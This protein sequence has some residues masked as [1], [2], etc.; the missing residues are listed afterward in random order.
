MT[1][2]FFQ[3]GFGGRLPGIQVAS[4]NEAY[5]GGFQE[6]P[7]YMPNGPY[8][9][10]PT[11]TFRDNVSKTFGKHNL[12]FG[13]YLV[14][15]QK[16]ELDG[17]NPSIGGFLTFDNT[18]A[19]TTGNA[20]A[21]L[22]M[23]KISSFQQQSQQVKYYNRY[24]IVEPYFQDD[25]RVTHKLTLNLGLRVSMFGTYRERYKQA[26]NFEAAKYLPGASSIDPA[27]GEVI[28]DQFNGMVQCGGPGIPPGCMKGHLFN[29]APRIGFAYDP[30]GDGKTAI[31]GGYG[32]FYEHTNGNEGNT[33]SLFGSPP[34][35]LN[36]TQSN[37]ASYDGVSGAL[38]LPLNVRSIP[39]SA[40]WPYMQQWHFDI[41]RD[42][43]AH[44]VATASYVGSKGTH[45]TLQRNLN[46]LHPTPLGDNPYKPGEAISGADCGTSFDEFGVPLN[47]TTPSG[48]PI[49]G[50]AAVNLAVAACG[51]NADV[52]RTEFPGFSGITRLEPEANSSYH[53]FQLAARRTIGALN[54]S[55]AYTYSHSIDNSSSRSDGTFVDSFDLARTRAN[56]NFDQRHILTISYVYDL[57][58]FKGGGIKNRVLGGWQFSGITSIQSGTPFTVQN[59][60]DFSDS[61][62]V[63]N[64]LVN[65][66]SFADIIGNPRSGFD[67]H[68]PGD[69][70]PRLYNPDAYAT[71]QGLTFGNSGRNSLTLPR[72]TNFDFS[73]FKRFPLGEAR[74]FEF[75]WDNF[76]VFNHT[77]FSAIDQDF[78]SSTFLE[79]T[80]AHS[81]RIMQFGAKII[82]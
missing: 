5:G 42:L 46:Q 41:Q 6:D 18:S 23:G 22:L 35:V 30:F 68:V 59:G 47:A 54:L 14:F 80:S 48:V 36:P 50:Q 65:A 81:A 17:S 38:P 79:A 82:F 40:V 75:R 33:E 25:W 3:N 27:T 24:K 56:S 19:F 37:I 2:G 45:L 51:A 8:N 53:A 13:A 34:L 9:S 26:F 55:L 1:L 7:G 15:A 10:N 49:T 62:G 16:N 31:R 58:F 29:P 63:A 44:V 4:G 76:N 67:R 28:G 52:L 57:P 61:A 32:I 70:G 64:G 21:D 20:F 78:G 60:T 73:L 43:P 77:Q 74:A 72:R 12:Q 66:G 39:T 71:P 69:V 11:Y